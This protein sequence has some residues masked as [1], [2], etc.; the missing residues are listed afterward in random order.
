MAIYNLAKKLELAI[1]L[2]RNNF[3]SNVSANEMNQSIYDSHD[4]PTK[5]LNE[6]DDSNQNVSNKRI[7]GT[8][9]I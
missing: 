1:D 4:E 3:K 9:S 5:I 6:L 7:L 8:N 2:K